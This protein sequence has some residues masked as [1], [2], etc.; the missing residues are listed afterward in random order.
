MTPEEKAEELIEKFKNAIE[1]RHSD[2]VKTIFATNCAIVCIKEIIQ[3]RK[4][5]AADFSF[6]QAVKQSLQSGG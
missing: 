5:L 3:D 6:E 2:E 1:D 4:D